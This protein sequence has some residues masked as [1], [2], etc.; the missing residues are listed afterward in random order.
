M[1]WVMCLEQKGATA[2]DQNENYPIEIFIR[3]HQ[4]I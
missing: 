4:E 2:F 1:E 3:S